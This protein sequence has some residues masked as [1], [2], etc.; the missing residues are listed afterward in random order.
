[1]IID[2]IHDQSIKADIQRCRMIAEDAENDAKSL[3]GHKVT[4]HI[5]GTNFGQIYASLSTL[6]E[7]MERLLKHV[8][9]K[10]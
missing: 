3:D 5:L 1:M 10:E 4:G 8:E 6:A 7:I 2:K 9:Q